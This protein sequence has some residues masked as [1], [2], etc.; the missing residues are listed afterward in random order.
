MRIVRWFEPWL[1]F[2]CQLVEMIKEA[3]ET[4]RDD[5]LALLGSLVGESQLRIPKFESEIMFSNM[6]PLYTIPTLSENGIY[7]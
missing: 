2:V 6:V 5:G 7:I 3:D 4:S 1:V